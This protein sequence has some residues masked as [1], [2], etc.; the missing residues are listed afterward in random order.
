MSEPYLARP[1]Q[2]IKEHL[3]NVLAISEGAVKDSMFRTDARIHNLVRIVALLHDVGK[4]TTYFQDKLRGRAVHSDLSNH[5]YLSALIGATYAIKN[6]A[7]FG[8][9]RYDPLIVFISIFSHHSDL[10]DAWEEIPKITKRS[11][12]Q[13][14]DFVLKEIKISDTTQAAR[15]DAL[16]KQL[17]DLSNNYDAGISEL[18]ELGIYIEKP[19]LSLEAVVQTLYTLRRLL[20]DLENEHDE[21]REKVALYVQ[22]AY[23]ILL[24]ADKKD[25]SGTK[26]AVR[27]KI[28]ADIVE[29]YISSVDFGVTSMKEVRERLRRVLT[30]NLE[31]IDYSALNGAILTITAPT[32]AGKTLAALNFAVKLREKIEQTKG[33]TP[34]IIYSL[35]YISII[36]QNLGVIESVLSSLKDFDTHRSEYLIAHYHLAEMEE[37]KETEPSDYASADAKQMLVESWDS[38]IIVTTFWQLLHTALGYKNRLMKK[39]HRLVGSIVILDEVQTIPAEHWPLVEKF[40]RL[41]S[42]KFSTIFVLMTATQPF[43]LNDRKL[44][45]NANFVEM[46]KSLDRTELVDATNVTS[47]DELLDLI[48]T[49]LAKTTRSSAL[50]VV[51]TVTESIRKY[52]MIKDRFGEDVYYMSTNITPRERFERLYRLKELMKEQKRV[53]LV[54]TQ[55]VEAGVDLDFDVVIRELSPL[56]SIIQVAGRCNRNGDKEKSKVYVTNLN[57]RAAKTVYGVIHIEVARQ[58][59]RRY[60]ER[61]VG[62]IPESQYAQMVREYFEE[63]KGRLTKQ[64]EVDEMWKNYLILRFRATEE[65]RTISDFRVIR[66]EP[67]ISIFVIRDESDQEVFEALREILNEKDRNKRSVMYAQV[68]RK[69]QERMIHVS[70]K[71]AAKNLPP[72]V[73]CYESLRFINPDSLEVFYSLETGFKYTEEELEGGVVW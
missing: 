54:S 12:M 40:F 68:K 64:A 45:L 32:G 20:N 62:R 2:T 42:E 47:D 14:L 65:E 55:V 49:N 70:V 28:P 26:P 58:L 10:P 5:S 71:R 41:L 8:L 60:F 73:D 63:I 37:E 53:I 15:I 44:E 31:N 48:E 66:S 61:N 3:S 39:F 1:G 22:L 34:R 6:S 4:Y 24:D 67:K 46:F 69:I 7:S 19:D 9:E 25:A 38:E 11:I 33:Y 57:E 29:N 50:V 16:K 13:G 51:N 21:V 59:L 72:A 23:S 35:P 27:R 43:I 52:R 30:D 18:S 56:H 17:A 36:E